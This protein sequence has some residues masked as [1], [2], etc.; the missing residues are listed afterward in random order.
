MRLLYLFS[1]LF[2]VVPLALASHPFAEPFTLNIGES[3][4]I[5]DDEV[6]VGFAEI[7]SDSRCPVGVWCFWEGD[8]AADLWVQYPGEEPQGFVLHTH[9]GF[10]QCLEIG[11]HTVCLEQVDP[12]PVY[13]DPIDPDSYLVT[14]VVYE[15]AVDQ[16][17]LLFGMIKSL[18][19]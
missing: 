17:Q 18:Y 16:D 3:I 10:D 14:M 8:A 1:F 11:I 4:Q 19:R 6:L 13:P 15:G 2:L 9:G 5:G 12:Y 7:L